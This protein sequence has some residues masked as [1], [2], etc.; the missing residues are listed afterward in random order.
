MERETKKVTTPSGTIVEFYTYLTGK[1]A[2]QLQSIFLKHSKFQTGEG[3]KTKVVD[4]DPMA[5]PEA[6]ETALRLVVV[7]VDGTPDNA[8]DRV[9]NL[10]QEDYRVVI[11][12]INDVTKNA[13]DPSDF[14]AK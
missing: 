13:F 8:A 12:A 1:E 14:L 5:V 11:K 3:D 9:E 4:F 10:R 7:S 2:R 6:E